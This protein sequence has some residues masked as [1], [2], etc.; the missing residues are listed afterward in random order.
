ML[1]HE[2]DVE[3]TLIQEF[4]LYGGLPSPRPPDPPTGTAWAP[5]F[6]P[7]GHYVHGT[8]I[9]QARSTPRT[10]EAA[11]KPRERKAPAARPNQRAHVELLVVAALRVPHHAV[12]LSGRAPSG[13]A[14][15][16]GKSFAER[17]HWQ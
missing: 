15:A 14:P 16:I 5:R 6:P 10:P 12:L 13:D 2:S 11:L 1:L 7:W 3:P 17:F 9:R 4:P 8:K